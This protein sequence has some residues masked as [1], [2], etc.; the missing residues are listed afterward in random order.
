MKLWT[1]TKKLDKPVGQWLL[2]GVLLYH[3]WPAYFDYKTGH[4]Y[5][6]Q[7]DKYLQYQ[8]DKKSLN[9]LRDGSECDWIPTPSSAPAQVETK[10]GMVTWEQ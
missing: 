9:T 2:S 5:V 8:Q 10:D 6:K 7:Y 1:P 4:L 3:T